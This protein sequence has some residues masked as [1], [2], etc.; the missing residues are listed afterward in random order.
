MRVA[1]AVAD[2]ALVTALS[3]SDSCKNEGEKRSTRL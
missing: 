2:F 3:G 1:N